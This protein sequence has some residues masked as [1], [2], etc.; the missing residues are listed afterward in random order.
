MVQE[1]LLPRVSMI[2]VKHVICE[3]LFI[4]KRV[5]MSQEIYYFT[6]ILIILHQILHQVLEIIPKFRESV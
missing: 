5:E 2:D 6:F 1:G 3:I 4:V